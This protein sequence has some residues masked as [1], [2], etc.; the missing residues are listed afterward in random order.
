MSWYCSFDMMVSFSGPSAACAGVPQSRRAVVTASVLRRSKG[1]LSAAAT[2][3]RR[4]TV[5]SR[6]GM[7]WF[8]IGA[9]DSPNGSFCSLHPGRRA[10]RTAVWTA[11]ATAPAAPPAV[12]QYTCNGTTAQQFRP[13]PTDSGHVCLANRNIPD[14]VL[15]VRGRSTTDNAPVQLWAYTGGT[16]QQ[17]KAVPEP[18][19]THHFAKRPRPAYS[20]PLRQRRML[21]A[22]LPIG[23][24][25]GSGPLLPP[26]PD[27]LRAVAEARFRATKAL[28]RNGARW[29]ALHRAP[30]HIGG[31]ASP[32]VGAQKHPGAAVLGEVALGT[33]GRSHH[34]PAG[35]DR[36]GERGDRGAG[37]VVVAN[38]FWL[39]FCGP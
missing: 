14:Q 2:C 30:R 37:D 6:P 35:V 32:P 34:T 12:P 38:R 7:D 3:R 18:A 29:A 22:P 15:D 21:A 31:S 17:R 24:A 16:S 26:P 19:G 33:P 23:G 8:G 4:L 5:C 36:A 1:S 27:R 13:M 25:K 10:P 39:K 11:P 9:S 28:A 20:A